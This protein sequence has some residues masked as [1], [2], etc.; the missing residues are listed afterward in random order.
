MFWM[1]LLF[2][3]V[4]TLLLFSLVGYGFRWRHPRAVDTGGGL[5]FLFFLFFLAMWAG[6]LWLVPVG[7]VL[8][9]SSWLSFLIVGIVLALLVMA[10]AA[11]SAP[12]PRTPAEAAEEEA[13]EVAS[14]AVV[15]NAFFWVFALILLVAIAARYWG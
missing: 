2:V 9:G 3:L 1:D 11:P 12:P 10:L 13:A 15:F 8:W 4:F 7:P 6:G 14:T 5:L